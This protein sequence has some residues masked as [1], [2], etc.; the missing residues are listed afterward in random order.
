MCTP[1]PFESP[2]ENSL[3][4]Q[5]CLPLRTCVY[6]LNLSNIFEGGRERKR[7][8]RARKSNGKKR[9]KTRSTVNNTIKARTFCGIRWDPER[10][11][12]RRA[13]TAA[14]DNTF[15]GRRR[16]SFLLALLRRLL[17]RHGLRDNYSCCAGSDDT[18]DRA[19][20]GETVYC[21]PG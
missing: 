11:R 8:E 5:K 10:R 13:A 2:K 12:D 21:W 9:Q 14:D 6:C 16:R 15:P 1:I 19:T 7:D 18:N 20:S 4:E 17:L 3:N